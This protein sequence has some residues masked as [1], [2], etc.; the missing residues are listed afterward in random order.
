[1]T[2]DERAIWTRGW[3]ADIALSAGVA[4]FMGL[5]GPF[6]S[7]TNGPAWQRI[8]YW[9]PML[10]LGLAVYGVTVR[11]IQSRRMRPARTWGLLGLACVVLN[12]PFSWVSWLWATTIWPGLAHVANLTPPVWYAEG[13]ITTV[14]IVTLFAVVHAARTRPRPEA[15]PP[16]PAGLLGAQPSEVLCLQME[17]HYVRVHTASGSRLVL[18]TLSQAI[19]ALGRTSGV[20]VHRSWWVADKAVA[21]AEAH[22]RNLRLVLVN[23]LSAPVARTSVAAVRSAGWLERRTP[24]APQAAGGAL[25]AQ[26]GPT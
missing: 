21:G 2:Q 20:Q 9:L 6:G 7:Y 25:A 4:V 24:Q 19:A 22:G 14:P 5:L 10:A 15:A 16:T 8:G 18:A 12:G 13:L 3:G 1:M 23:G 11:L 17:D 26:N